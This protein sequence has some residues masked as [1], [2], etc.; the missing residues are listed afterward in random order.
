MRRLHIPWERL[1]VLVRAHPARVLAI[2]LLVLVPPAV[3]AGW[4][5][6]SFSELEDM[7]P[8]TESVRGFDAIERHYDRGQVNPLMVIVQ[9]D[10][11]LWSE[12]AF[13][14]VND[15]TIALG[16][17]PGVAAVRSL[18]QPTGGRFTEA[19]LEEAGVGALASFPD[20]LEEGAEGVGQVLGG[21]ARIRDGLEE[22]GA[23]LPELEGGL[24]E[25]AE[26]VEEIREGIA[27]MREG[28]ARMRAGLL[29][30]AGA[31][32]APGEGNDLGDLAAG[33]AASLASALDRMHRTVP[34]PGVDPQYCTPDPDEPSSSCPLYEDVASAYGML[35]GI[36]D[37]TGEPPAN[38]AEAR[39]YHEAGGMAGSLRTI[40]AGLR[41]AEDGL[42]RID[43]GLA[44]M[45]DGLARLAGGLREGAGGVARAVDGARRMIEGVDRIVPGLERLRAGLAEGAARVRSAGIGDAA[46]AGN[47]GLTPGLVEAIPGLREQLSFF[48]SSDERATRLLV[49]LEHDPFSRDALDAVERIREIGSFA[50]NDTA[51]EGAPVLTA[52]TAP[53][54]SDIRALSSADIPVIMAAVLAGIFLVLVALL[55]SLVAPLYLILT[56]LLSF[57]TTLGLTV[58]LF[59]GLLGAAGLPWWLPPFLFVM[60]VAL[61]GD[62]NIFL[63]SRIRE[64]AARHTTEEATAR[65][66]ALT[67]PVITSAGLILAGTFAAL[68]ATPLR[69]LQVFGF[70]VTVGI[71]LD[72][73]VVRSLTVP[74]IST[75]L[76]RHNWWPSRRAHAA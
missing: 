49:T 39:R 64:E 65:G 74:A 60:L 59:Q 53:F 68:M 11:P 52:G 66:L 13:R 19:D 23:R 47:L 43:G 1:A 41:E 25:G 24:E 46:A 55:R 45:D 67:G 3:A 7:P 73:L 33:A 20:R 15:V 8:G 27:Q 35:T 44:R 54:F 72:T 21:L 12:G 17:V 61:G 18:T 5:R 42:G 37:R 70:A 16:K 34:R 2:S 58:L 38:D 48:L 9:H 51:L 32:E 22:M 4:A 36:D 75:L 50:L 69:N 76:G 40:A 63:M 28:V 71:L 57:A 26:G 29:E 31:L 30:A 62:Y 10:E 56:V 6:Y 14:A